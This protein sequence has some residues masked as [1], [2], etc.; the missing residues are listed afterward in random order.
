MLL[1][2]I[3]LRGTKF[4]KFGYSSIVVLFNMLS[5]ITNIVCKYMFVCVSTVTSLTHSN[6]LFKSLCYARLSNIVFDHALCNFEYEGLQH[7]V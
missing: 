2:V 6:K 3:S 5:S 1:R 7:A 4:A